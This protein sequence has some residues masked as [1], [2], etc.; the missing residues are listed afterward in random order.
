MPSFQPSKKS[1]EEQELLDT[2]NARVSRLHGSDD[3][4]D[5]D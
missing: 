4:E 5:Q 3:R 2:K 1:V